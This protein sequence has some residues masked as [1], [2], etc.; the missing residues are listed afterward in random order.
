MYRK[1]IKNEFYTRLAHKEGYPARS[2][3]KLKEIDKKFHLV[4]EGDKVLDL[5]AAP[6]SWLL[7]LSEKVGQKGKVLGFD[8][9]DIKIPARNNVVFYKKS[10]LDLQPGDFQEKYD[11]VAAD[12]SPKTSGIRDI[13]VARSLELSEAALEIAKMTLV[14]GGSFVC[15]IFETES[16]PEFFKKV[17]TL[18]KTAK[19]FRPMAA[20]KGS[21]EFY[22]IGKEFKPSIDKILK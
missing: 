1:G 2:V 21:R 10:I 4:K 13:D 19:R 6:G 14:E 11:A 7:Y 3:Y 15:K 17:K 18:F 5:G 16:T 22:I 9:E 20:P 12:L 8:I